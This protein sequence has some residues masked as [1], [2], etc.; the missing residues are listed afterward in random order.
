MKRYTWKLGIAFVIS[1]IILMVVVVFAYTQI[2]QNFIMNQ[3][4]DQLTESGEVVSKQIELQLTYDYANFEN[5]VTG[6]IEDSL[7]P[8]VELD[9][10][11]DT[12]TIL[13]GTY[14]HFG[15]IDIDNRQVTINDQ[16]YDFTDNF[17]TYNFNQQIGFYNF[18]R[19]FGTE[20]MTMYGVFKVDEYVAMFELEPY[21][22][23]FLTAEKIE[24][25]YV[26][27]GEENTIYVSSTLNPDEILFY[28]Y[29]REA[30]YS[31]DHI[32]TI[33]EVVVN[34]ES[35]IF[36]LNFLDQNSILSFVPVFSDLTPATY[37]L[38]QIYEET[39]VINS[40]TY[41]STTLWALFAVIF[42]LFSITIIVIYKILEE[43]I[44]DI[45]NARLS[46]YYAKPYIIKVKKSG[47]I[48]SYNRAFNQLLGDTDTYSNI[49]D[50]VIKESFEETSVVE[51]LHRQ[52][53]FTM[54]LEIMDKAV[55]IRFI[56]TRSTGGYILV[57]DDITHIEGKF[58]E[59]EKLAL[60]NPVTNLP[61][62]NVLISDLDKVFQDQEILEQFNVIVTFDIVAFSKIS[63]VLGEES[64]DRFLQFI[65]ELAKESLENYPAKL[66]N[67]RVDQFAILFTNLESYQ[68]INT[69]VDLF[70]NKLD[71]PIT[72]DR[73]FLNVD[74][75]I[76]IFN[77]ESQKY[78]ILTS[79]ICL[80]NAKLALNHAKESST[81]P[82]FLYDV[83]LSLVASREQRM[84]L[85]L[86]N[87]ITNQE[88][89]MALQAQYSNVEERIIG[90]EALIRWTNPKYSAESPLKFIQMAEHNNMIV[91]IGRIALH[92]TFLI[93]KELE[94]YNVHISINVSPVQMLQAGFVNEVI[95]IFEQYDLKPGSISLEITETFLIDSFELVINKLNIFKRH[96]FNI[97]LDDFGTGYSSLQ[98]LRDLPINT[99]KI[100]KAFIDDVETDAHSRAIVTMI[101]NL[102]KNIDLDV[103]AEGV[104]TERQNNIVFKAGCNVI[105]GYLIGPPVPK[106]VAIKLIEDYNINKT[107]KIH[108]IK[109]KTREA[110]R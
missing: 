48:R 77:I 24:N 44:H 29:L 86:A 84:E 10:R 100:D 52:K 45:E 63:L 94:P 19:A 83:S 20:D 33:K 99:I 46:L 76:G 78:E 1:Y 79:E 31:E 70:L 9:N 67:L 39:T 81:K 92:E 56:V 37:Y 97:H 75:K 5:L 18:K 110:K 74:V 80:E 55:Y 105:Q 17:T 85:D 101:S 50:F 108:V 68:W 41:L 61:N 7:D 8:L 95:S 3:A 6:F 35:G 27:M 43:K 87:A 47:K 57:G 66:Y 88:F 53:A 2:S 21:M 36:S 104:E 103:I 106:E 34:H 102:A 73:N 32:D 13:G 25:E 30:G 59:F 93:A 38:V 72:M 71:K 69:W 26:F 82:S 28:N 12:I 64:G 40:L 14:S 11:S 54:I 90:F 15:S 96:G 16:T 60:F 51:R 62:Q 89:Q 4:E 107:K 58:D 22:A 65:A 42:V 109:T 49:A 23:T 91:D 98:Y